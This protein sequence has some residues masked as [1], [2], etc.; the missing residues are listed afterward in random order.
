M[1]KLDV[2][3]LIALAFFCFSGTAY[4]KC[5]IQYTSKAAK[6]FGSAPRGNFATKEQCLDY[7]R[8]SPAFERADSHCI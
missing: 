8:S 7:W 2:F 6:M 5:Q 3:L 4:A 1:K